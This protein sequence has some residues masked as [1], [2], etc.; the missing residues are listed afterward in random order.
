MKK[1]IKKITLLN[2]F[3]NIIL[4]LCTIISGFIIPKLILLYFGSNVNGLVSSINQFLSYITLIEGGITGVAMAALYKPLVENDNKGI[5][6]ILLTT[7]LFYKKIGLI[8]ILYSIILS[9]VYPIFIDKSGFSFIYV[10]SLILTLS[11]SLFIQYMF[12]L[13][14]R[15]L[16]NAD[17]KIYIVSC[18]QIVIIILNILLSILSLRIYPDIHILKFISC[19]LFIIQPV[20]FNYYVKK[21]YNI[22]KNVPKSKELLKYRWDGFAVNLASFIH[23]STDI[24]LLTIMTDLKTVSIYSVYSLVTTGLRTLISS[25]SSAIN[26]I[27]GQAYAKKDINELLTKLDMFEYI[28]FI[29]VF[30]C[31]TIAAFL[32]TPFVMVYT[33]GISDANYNQNIFGILIVISEAIYLLKFP[34][35]S[36]AYSAN[37]FKDLKVPSF[38]EALINII[39]SLILVQKLGLIGVTIGTII[40]MTYRL[41]FHIRFTTTLIKDRKPIIFYKKLFIFSIFTLVGIIFSILFIPVSDFNIGS[42]IFHA[43]LYIIIFGIDYL[44][45]SLVFFKKEIKYIKRYIKQ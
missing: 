37:K 8:Y 39:I 41:I 20:V 43:V 1:S 35:L 21:N 32:I 44:T 18:T 5:S 22:E 19:I 23:F 24:T 6:S 31:F 29:L 11:L 4:Q 2:I 30:F 27:I 3:S 36:L 45:M 10:S 16:L 7:D 15:T 12:S 17:K 40:A 13:T 9:F 28:I 33:N 42:W 25:I 38:I 34:H 14:L 26:P